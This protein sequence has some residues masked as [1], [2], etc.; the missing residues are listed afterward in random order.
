MRNTRQR[1]AIQGV[2]ESINRPL[3]P[4]EVLQMAQAEVPRLGIA[5]VYRAIRSLQES[6]WLTTVEL[7]GEPPRYERAH[8]GH[9]HH[10]RCRECSLVFEVHGCP[11]G[12]SQMAPKGFEIESHEVVLYGRCQE[13]VPAT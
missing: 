7:P 12:L 5:T 4:T 8:L 13:C 11:T 9:H 6:G 2:F 1:S 10:F 3:A